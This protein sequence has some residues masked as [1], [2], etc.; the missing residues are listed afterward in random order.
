MWIHTQTQHITHW[1]PIIRFQASCVWRLMEALKGVGPSGLH[2]HILA[3]CYRYIQTD[4]ALMQYRYYDY[5]EMYVR[6]ESYHSGLDVGLHYKIHIFTTPHLLRA[7][8]SACTAHWHLFISSKW[9]Y[10]WI[11]KT[12][13]VLRLFDAIAQYYIIRVHNLWMLCYFLCSHMLYPSRHDKF[14]FYFFAKLF[15]FVFAIYILCVTYLDSLIIAHASNMQLLQLF[16]LSYYIY[17]YRHAFLMIHHSLM[18]IEYN[19]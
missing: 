8:W 17:I 19:K 7:G 1:S 13:I 5:H 6:Y 11:I 9:E 15:Q 12:K 3:Y 10:K 14:Y 4:R 2:R 18:N 16:Q